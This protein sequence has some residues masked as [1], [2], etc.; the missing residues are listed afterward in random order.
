MTCLDEF[1]L[2]PSGVW[3]ERFAAEPG[4]VGQ[5]NPLRPQT[6]TVVQNVINE[7]AE[8]F[9]DDF[10]HGGGDEVAPGCWNNSS[11]IRVGVLA[12]P[13]LIFLLLRLSCACTPFLLLHVS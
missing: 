9:S 4:G 5:L 8:L 13:L 7:V 3:S 10:Y 6:Y 12:D 2:A 1:W 11:D